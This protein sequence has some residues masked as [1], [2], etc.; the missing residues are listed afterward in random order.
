MLCPAPPPFKYNN[1]L[2]GLINSRESQNKPKANHHI[3]LPGYRFL[4]L[5]C[6]I[7]SNLTTV[8]IKSNTFCGHFSLSW[9]P[10][11]NRGH[12]SMPSIFA[13]YFHR[14][15]TCHVPGFHYIVV[16]CQCPAALQSSDEVWWW[17]TPCEVSAAT[18]HLSETSSVTVYNGRI[19]AQWYSG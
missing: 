8:L 10:F 4:C 17:S 19:C 6:K 18:L 5:W 3:S 9:F 15:E 16:C 11:K 7:S 14:C 12:I 1:L 2:S 13:I